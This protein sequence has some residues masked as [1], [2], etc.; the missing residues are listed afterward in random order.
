MLFN[1]KPPQVTGKRK[2]ISVFGSTGT[3]GQKAVDII[4]ENRELYD[5]VVL[6]ANENVDLLIKQAKLLKPEYAVIVN[7]E[8]FFKLQK[9]LEYYDIK[10]MSGKLALLEVSNITCDI[11]I[12]A[13]VGNA[14]F[15]PLMKA[16]QAGSNIGL[17]NK[18][19]LVT[20]GEIIKKEAKN[21]KVNIIPI[22]S[23]HNAIFQSLDFN[24]LDNVSDI[25]LTASGGPFR[26]FTFEEMKYVTPEQALKHPNWVMGK[27]ISID[28]ATMMNKG[29]EMIEAFHLF[30]L[31][32]EQ[33]N[34][35]LHRESIVHGFVNYKDGTTLAMMNIPDMR[36]PISYTINYPTR[37]TITH[38][39]L[40]LAEIGKLTFEE[41]DH[42]RFPSV[43]MCMDALRE[44]DNMPCILSVANEVAVESFLKKKIGFLDIAIV[45]YDAMESMNKYHLATL[46]DVFD[47]D[48][49]TREIANNIVKKYSV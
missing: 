38:K 8:L 36:I 32:Q 44:G 7:D 26:D 23:E 9:E 27:K 1:K 41:I 34:A 20:A 46:D 48:K 24:N 17:A 42:K 11:N 47:C 22:D 21:H 25:V 40:N 39:K 31:K 13:I 28:S 29:L 6:T 5:V 4:R 10:T 12:C 15:E 37:L 30:G 16:I 19:C 35:V 43:N 3:I 49:R 2:R 18:E 45:V 14:A 33:I